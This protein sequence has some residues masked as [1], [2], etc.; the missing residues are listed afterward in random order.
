MGK[1]TTVLITGITGYLGSNLA[2]F[3]AKRTYKII[4]IV[5]ENSDLK[6]L[7]DIYDH[8]TLYNNSSRKDL[9]LAFTNH[10][11]DIIIHTAT[12]YGRADELIDQILESNV[13][14][15]SM[16]L[17]IAV[18]H[19]VPVFINTDTALPS[20]LNLYS[21][22]KH[23]FKEILQVHSN[24]IKVINLKLEYFFGPQDKKNKFIT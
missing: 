10:P 19:S 20:E 17:E 14:F 4:G 22:T 23:L 12:S 11:I 16:L 5:R 3:L 1:I 15:P 8:I 21:L 13:V 18:K 9:E 6:E 7:T 2:K 24:A